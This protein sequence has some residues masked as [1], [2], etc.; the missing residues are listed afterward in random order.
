[1]RTAAA[2]RYQRRFGGT[3][4]SY[5]VLLFASVWT[6]RNFDPSGAALI[7]LSILPALPVIAA[8]AVMGIYLTEETDEFVRDRIV[9]AMLVAVGILLSLSTILGFLQYSGVIDR[10]DVFWAFPVW[11]LSWGFTQCLFSLRSRAEGEGE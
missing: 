7:A 9:I 10:V 8:L 6:I 5:I 4:V 11:C 2:K 3:M 1:M